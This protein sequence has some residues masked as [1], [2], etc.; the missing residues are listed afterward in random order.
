M[1]KIIFLLFLFCLSWAL[2]IQGLEGTLA[3]LRGR[4]E[5]VVLKLKNNTSETENLKIDFFADKQALDQQYLDLLE[6]VARQ[7]EIAV[8]PNSER[9][10]VFQIKTNEQT[11]LGEYLFWLTFSKEIHTQNNDSGDFIVHDVCYYPVR[12]ACRIVNALD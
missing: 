6:S 1:R 7:P 12:F 8:P 5:R 10:Y 11:E 3:V 2:E 9:E 4:T